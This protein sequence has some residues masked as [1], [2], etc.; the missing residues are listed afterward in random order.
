MWE[1]YTKNAQYTISRDHPK[2]K[3][4]K[5]NYKIA[6][7]HCPDWAHSDQMFLGESDSEAGL[8]EWRPEALKTKLN[9]GELQ[10]S[11]PLKSD[12]SCSS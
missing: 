10:G 7:G 4:N 12:G 1:Q 6:K 3:L 5:E 2:I 9:L 11:S 8:C